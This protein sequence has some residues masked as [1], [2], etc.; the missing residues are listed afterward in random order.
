MRKTRLDLCSIEKM[1]K[2]LNKMP[3]DAPKEQELI[4]KI[5]KRLEDMQ[6]WCNQRRNEAEKRS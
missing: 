1:I 6:Q 4:R 2:T 3:I 5:K